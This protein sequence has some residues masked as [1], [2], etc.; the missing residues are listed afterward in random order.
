M[1]NKGKVEN[2]IINLSFNFTAI[3]QPSLLLGNR[4]ENRIGES[5]AQFILKTLSFLFVGKLRQ[6]KAI[7]ALNVANAIIRIISSNKQDIYFTS[8]KLEELNKS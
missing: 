4:N 3:I 6:F 2:Y 7:P 5:I 8:D 1:Q